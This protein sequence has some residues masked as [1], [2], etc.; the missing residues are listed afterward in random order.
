MLLTQLEMQVSRIAV[1]IEQEVVTP[2]LQTFP[3]ISLAMGKYST[4]A[5][6]LRLQDWSS[7][8]NDENT[9]PVYI[10]CTCT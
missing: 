2:T 1:L 10:Y 4:T 8:V 5:L 6:Y 3:I 7:K 9:R